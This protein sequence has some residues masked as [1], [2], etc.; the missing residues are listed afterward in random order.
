MRDGERRE[1]SRSHFKSMCDRGDTW[2]SEKGAV[3]NIR[4]TKSYLIGDKKYS[5]YFPIFKKA[6][7]KKAEREEIGIQELERE[8]GSAV[9]VTEDAVHQWR[10]AKSAPGDLD[11]VATVATFLNLSDKDLLLQVEEGS[12]DR[13]TDR[14]RE[15]VSIIYREIEDYLLLFEHSDGFV[16]NN[17]R[18]ESGSPYFKYVATAADYSVD[19]EAVVFTD[20]SRLGEASWLYVAHVL[21]REWVDL[22]NH[23]LFEELRGFID[24]ELLDI[25]NGKTDPDYRFE[26][27]GPDDDM[28]DRC[29]W[30][31][32][33]RVRKGLRELIGR[34]L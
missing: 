3:M 13:L 33:E 4:R 26:P 18:I 12:L 31:D 15:S 19:G 34:Y 23:P 30:T 11:M 17:Y 6:F 22:G 2:L 25:W 28:S 24:E 10:F 8:L 16:W 1:T 14:Q 7:D 27:N 5:F 21:E 29:V 20:G 9:G 32:S